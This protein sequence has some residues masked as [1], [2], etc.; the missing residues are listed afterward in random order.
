MITTLFRLFIVKS[1]LRSLASLVLVGVFPHRTDMKPP[2]TFPL[3]SVQTVRVFMCPLRKRYK[4]TMKQLLSLSHHNRL[5]ELMPNSS[6]DRRNAKTINEFN[7]FGGGKTIPLTLT[8]T[9]FCWV[10]N[11]TCNMTDVMLAF[12]LSSSVLDTTN[13]F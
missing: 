13:C 9:A 1:Q 7:R 8:K 11:R 10:I 6:T 12:V 3:L 4:W 5:N 2:E